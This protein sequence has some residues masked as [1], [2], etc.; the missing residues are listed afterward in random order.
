MSEKARAREEGER[1]KEREKERE[2]SSSHPPT[3]DSAQVTSPAYVSTANINPPCL[4]IY[5]MNPLELKLKQSQ[6]QFTRNPNC[7]RHL[8]LVLMAE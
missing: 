5:P 2:N 7:G 8:Q 1:E 6:Q 4:I 3:L